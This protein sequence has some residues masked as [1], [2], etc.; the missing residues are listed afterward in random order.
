MDAGAQRDGAPDDHPIPVDDL[1][2]AVAARLAAQD[3]VE[4]LVGALALRADDR[5]PDDARV[6][7]QRAEDAPYPVGED[8]GVRAVV[9]PEADDERL[10]RELLEVQP[11]RLHP[12]RGR[13]PGRSVI[14]SPRYGRVPTAAESPT[15]STCAG[16]ACATP[17]PGVQ[18]AI[19]QAARAPPRQ[20][21]TF[22]GPRPTTAMTACSGASRQTEEKQAAYDGARARSRRPS[23]QGRDAH[24]LH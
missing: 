20:T 18:A 8:R 13:P 22:Q 1:Q 14:I 2:P 10:R 4:P 16:S 15:M 12:L 5:R 21:I 19:R 3:L 24:R 9:R 23:T 17:P 6:R 7:G 11:Q